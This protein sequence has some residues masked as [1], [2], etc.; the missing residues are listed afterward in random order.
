MTTQSKLPVV[1]VLLTNTSSRD[2]CCGEKCLKKLK[3][4]PV[5]SYVIERASPQVTA[6]ILNANGDP[7]RFDSV[8]LPIVPDSIEEHRGALA[9]I[10]TGMEWAHE[11]NPNCEWIATFS[12]DSPFIPM[13]LVNHMLEEIDRH[14][15]DMAFVSCGGRPHPEYGLWPVELADDLR[16]A[17]LEEDIKRIDRWTRLYD[18][19][20][21][22]YPADPIDCFSNTNFIDGIVTVERAATVH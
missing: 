12:A 21:V 13:D 9:G 18:T 8:G 14:H 15:A 4:K 11:N 16:Y 17:L 10:L 20:T 7:T 5:L 2:T 6:L 22:E 1:G 19:I 3:G